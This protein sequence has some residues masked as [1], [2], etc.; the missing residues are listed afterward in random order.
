MPAERGLEKLMSGEGE[1]AGRGETGTGRHTV[2]AGTAAG[3][4]ARG[5]YRVRG[6]VE[7][8]GRSVP[9]QPGDAA[10]VRREDSLGEEPWA[11]TAVL[12]NRPTKQPS[13]P[14]SL[15]DSCSPLCHKPTTHPPLLCS[16]PFLQLLQ[17]FLS[18]MCKYFMGVGYWCG[19]CAQAQTLVGIFV[20]GRVSAAESV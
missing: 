5:P 14:N 6:V 12:Y 2:G 15:V 1:G 11:T 8:H 16:E 18:D 19:V 4:G 10:Q 17:R 13:P 9:P 20:L 3:A 7:K